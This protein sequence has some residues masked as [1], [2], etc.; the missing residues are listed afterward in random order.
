MRSPYRRRNSG[1]TS[2]PA[3]TQ[4]SGG[5]ASRK[6][7][8]SCASLRAFASSGARQLLVHLAHAA[9]FGHFARGEP[10]YAS[11]TFLRVPVPFRYAHRASPARSAALLGGLL[12][13]LERLARI[14]R[15]VPAALLV[16]QAEEICAVAS[17]RAA[18]FSNSA[19]AAASS[20][21]T[22]RPWRAAWRRGPRRPPRRR[23]APRGT[24]APPP[25]DRRR[26]R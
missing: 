10:P 24:S 7:P 12:P 13:P 14:L 21:G 16:E 6:R 4:L 8:R 18:A 17:P 25:R 15:R 19:R 23:R 26:R 3:K 5:L 11:T 1:P 2:S 20:F 9:G 22:P